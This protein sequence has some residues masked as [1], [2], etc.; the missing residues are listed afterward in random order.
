M[1]TGS[2]VLAPPAARAVGATKVYGQGD[3]EVRAIDGIDIE[4][5]PARFTAIMGPSGSG[6]STLMQCMA[7]LDRLTSGE[8]WIGDVELT[9]LVRAAAHEG[10]ARPGRLHLPVIQSGSDPDGAR[11]HPAAA[12]HRRPRSRRR[13]DGPGHRRAS[14]ARAARST[15]PPSSRAGSSSGS[16]LRGRWCRARRSSSRTSR[17]ASSIRSRR[18]SCLA[19]MRA[20]RGRV[21]P[22][23]RDGHARADRGELAP[24][25]W[26]SSLTGG[27]WT[28][29][30]EPTPESILDR[31]KTLEA[32]PRT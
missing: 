25:A 30:T 22:D 16:P 23:H 9:G 26:C 6:K 5:A 27:S 28:R 21:R 7:G 14:S 4:F 17:P 12:G 29:W 11:E 32:G 1:T 8:T 15:G 3:A 24:T 18:R 31:M 13:L 19:F 10:A 2:G 20:R